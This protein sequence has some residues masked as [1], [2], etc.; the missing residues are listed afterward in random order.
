MKRL[1][2]LTAGILI[3]IT[4]ASALMGSPSKTELE[5]MKKIVGYF[6]EWGIYSGHNNYLPANVPMEKVTHINYAFA[7]IK[8]GLIA[9]FDTYAATE[10]S[11]GETWDSPYKGNLGQFEKLKKDSAPLRTCFGRWLEPIGELS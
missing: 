4:A 7:T 2:K 11:Q 5:S 10:A 8:D 6:P 3:S 1:N 9:H